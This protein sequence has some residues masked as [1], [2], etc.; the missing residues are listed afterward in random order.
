MNAKL[1]KIKLDVIVVTLAVE[2]EYAV[3]VYIIIGA[4]VKSQHVS[5]QMMLKGIMIGLLKTL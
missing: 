2:K 1:K 5:S 3:N 4:V